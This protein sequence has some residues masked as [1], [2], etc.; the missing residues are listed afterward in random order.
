MDAD[1]I[2]LRFIDV[3]HNVSF[4]RSAVVSSASTSLPEFH[5]RV[6][7]GLDVEGLWTPV[8]NQNTTP[9]SRGGSQIDAG[10]VH[11]WIPSL[12]C[13]REHS[14]WCRWG[15][16]ARSR[17]V[18]RC[19]RSLF[20]LSSQYFCCLYIACKMH[21]Y[22]CYEIF[23]TMYFGLDVIN[24]FIYLALTIFLQITQAQTISLEK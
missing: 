17:K 10:S 21:L 18:K 7:F 20:L 14:L 13:Q 8:L 19:L 1:A 2:P 22:E 4:H 16:V 9:S 12:S 23:S 3:A 6:L 11:W 5:W 24:T 15:P